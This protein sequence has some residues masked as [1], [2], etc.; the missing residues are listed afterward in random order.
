MGFL[1]KSLKPPSETI[2]VAVII[3]L[4]CR[5]PLSVAL[6]KYVAHLV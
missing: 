6:V 2:L 4:K 5:F 3:Y 1:N